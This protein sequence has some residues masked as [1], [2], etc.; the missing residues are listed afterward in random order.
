M[1]PESRNPIPFDTPAT[2]QIIVQGRIDPAWADRL[3]GMTIQIISGE[4][5]FLVSS[6]E[7]ELSDQVALSGN[8]RS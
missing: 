5:E 2:Y 4:A 3:E 6:I 1:K 7:G 8:L